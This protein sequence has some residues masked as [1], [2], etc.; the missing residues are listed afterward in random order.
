MK[1][2]H[3]IQ[4]RP[5]DLSRIEWD[6][7]RKIRKHTDR[8]GW[9][10][11]LSEIA[12]MTGFKLSSIKTSLTHLRKKKYIIRKSSNVANHIFYNLRGQS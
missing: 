6:I 2:S 7:Y 8:W 9:G 12:D 5:D 11:E 10:L 3:I 1:T 4:A